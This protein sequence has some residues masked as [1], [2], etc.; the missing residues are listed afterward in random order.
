MG[1]E[2]CGRTFLRN[3]P[4]ETLVE[5]L[6]LLCK[7]RTLMTTVQGDCGCSNRSCDEAT[8]ASG[9]AASGSRSSAPEANIL[10]EIISHGSVGGGRCWM[11]MMSVIG[12]LR[13]RVILPKQGRKKCHLQTAQR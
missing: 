11:G 1:S 7:I 8:A 3:D 5:V 9:L 6:V 2:N 10:T 4:R 13:S 12:T